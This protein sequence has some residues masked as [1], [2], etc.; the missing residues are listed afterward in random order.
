M[1][2]LLVLVATV[3]L[4]VAFFFWRRSSLSQSRLE[5]LV[6][7]CLYFISLALALRFG[8]RTYPGIFFPNSPFLNALLNSNGLFV[9]VGYNAVLTGLAAEA[10]RILTRPS[11]P[12]LEAALKG[13][14]WLAVGLAGTIALYGFSFAAIMQRLP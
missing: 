4:T 13:V 7:T 3:G 5:A 12:G 6:F 10:L 9:G 8:G 1:L 14:K 2:S 11:A